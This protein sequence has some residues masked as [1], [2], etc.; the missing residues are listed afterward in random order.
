MSVK[1][2]FKQILKKVLWQIHPT[3]YRKLVNYK[4]RIYSIGIFTGNSIDRLRSGTSINNPV[5]T[6]SHVT[7]VPADFV[8]DPFMCK[9]GDRWFMFFEVYSKINYL[10]QIGLA[11]SEDGLNWVYDRIVLSE[12]FHMAYPYVFN[13][14]NKYYMIPDT[15]GNGVRLYEATDFPHKWRH[16][17]HIIDD[18]YFVDSSVF[19]FG[20][21]WWMF[22]ASAPNLTDPKTLRLY[23]ADEPTG[24]WQEHSKSPIVEANNSITRPGGR[25]LI[26]NG[27]PVRFAQDGV[28]TY[29]SRVRAFEILELSSTDYREQELESSPVLS[30]GDKGWNQGGMHHID[31][32]MIADNTWRACVDGWTSC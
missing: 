8:A 4:G 9:H 16:I 2:N 25:V 22:T 21:R 27:R 15:P 29:G 1:K 3:L 28:P 23:Y 7:D 6:A 10:G 30:A 11:T 5:L 19:F 20:D 12:P 24:N 31:G 32:H 14:R 18:N 26:V 13:W 17:G